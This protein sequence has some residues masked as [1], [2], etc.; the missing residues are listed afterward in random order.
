LGQ[1]FITVPPPKEKYLDENGNVTIMIEDESGRIELSGNRIYRE[2]LVT[3]CVVGVLGSETTGGQF[4]V[5]DVCLPEM[6][7][8]PR[9]DE[10]MGASNLSKPVLTADDDMPNFIAFASGLDI[11]GDMH[12][13]LETHLM[14]EY[15]T[16]E[17]LCPKVPQTRFSRLI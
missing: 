6:P 5:L 9:V 17:L 4:D 14:M 16:G 12:E 7:P 3:G 15:L 1:H 11:S 8:Q 2:G 10:K 13:S